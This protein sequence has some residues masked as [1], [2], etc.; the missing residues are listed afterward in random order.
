MQISIDKEIKAGYY[1]PALLLFCKLFESYRLLPPEINEAKYK[2]CITAVTRA[3][4]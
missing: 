2:S 3:A 1:G 4:T